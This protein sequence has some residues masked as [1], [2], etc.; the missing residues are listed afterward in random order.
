M[1]RE[2]RLI[3]EINQH[4]QLSQAC[5]RTIGV[6]GNQ[7]PRC[8]LLD[9]AIHCRNCD[10]FKQATDTLQME[11]SND[12]PQLVTDELPIGDSAV[13]LFRMGELWFGILPNTVHLV[14]SLSKIHR[15]PRQD[16]V[17]IRGI[18]AINGEIH[19][20]L[21]LEKLF[22]LTLSNKKNSATAVNIYKRQLLVNFGRWRFVFL[23][24]ELKNVYRFFKRDITE[25]SRQFNH[26]A[27]ALLIGKIACDMLKNQPFYYLDSA[28]IARC[29]DRILA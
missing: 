28:A 23:V 15:L 14:A 5:W 16:R 27:N 29:L 18:V 13:L 2:N 10:V 11:Y 19:S 4:S 24:D 21:A 8:P 26:Q 12:A 6:W 17:Y 20:C 7:L 3:T 22:G 25:T 1:K 9:K